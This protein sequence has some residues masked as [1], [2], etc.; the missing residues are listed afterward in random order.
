MVPNRTEGSDQDAGIGAAEIGLHAI[1]PLASAVQALA[2]RR[3]QDH[4]L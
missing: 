4:V 3:T 1:L 2:R